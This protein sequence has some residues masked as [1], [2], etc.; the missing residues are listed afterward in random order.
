MA[1]ATSQS[2]PSP[3]ELNAYLHLG[4]EDIV[5]L[6]LCLMIEEALQGEL[7][8]FPSAVT[9]H[10]ARH[11]GVGDRAS[12][13]G[14]PLTSPRPDHGAIRGLGRIPHRLG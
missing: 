13:R 4:R 1:G 14:A 2:D 3:E 11:F 12:A 5:R 6:V 10:A 7:A 9:G 8:F